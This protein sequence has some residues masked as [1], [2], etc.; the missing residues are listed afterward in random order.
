MIYAS[1]PVARVR[2]LLSIGLL[3][4]DFVFSQSSRHIG[5]NG[6]FVSRGLQ[7]LTDG[8]TDLDGICAVVQEAFTTDVRCEC[9]GSPERFLS[10][11]CDYQ[12][13]ICGASGENCGRPLIGVSVVE[14][15]MFSSTS[16]IRDYQRGS[17]KL[18]GET[19]ISVTACENPQDGLCGCIASY[20][21]QVCSS[22][23]V[24]EGGAGL[25][26]DCTNVNAEAVSEPCKKID[27]DLDLSGGAGILGNFLPEMAG[28]CTGLERAL[29]NRV[30][31]D[32]SRAKGGSYTITCKT[33]EENQQDKSV[34]VLSSVDVIEGAVQTVT[35][36]TDHPD[37]YG[38]T[39]TALQFC[40]DDSERVCS[41]LATYDDQSC[42][43]CQVCDGGEGV[44]VDCSNVFEQAS[45][46]ECQPVKQSTSFEFVPNFPFIE[47]EK[48][49][50]KSDATPIH[51]SL[52]VLF[53]GFLILSCLA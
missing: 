38:K 9:F 11:T 2:L 52:A 35:A 25:S 3:M 49:V 24:C 41:C 16:C 46:Q 7:A 32:C 29:D 21:S 20:E 27:M 15:K 43:M 14:G 39:C 30:S 6:D 40:E 44:Q 1:A 19:C 18:M 8:P 51:S 48:N 13:S 47:S 37:P 4:T 28:L 23:N 36:C 45:V 10:I 42:R 34:S 5:M 12:S 33:E 17:R 50:V 22:C 26:F 31:C 53:A